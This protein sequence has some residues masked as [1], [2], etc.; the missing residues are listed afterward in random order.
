MKSLIHLRP[1]RLPQIQC[2]LWERQRQHLRQPPRRQSVQRL[3]PR[4]LRERMRSI[5]PKQGGVAAGWSWGY[6]SAVTRSGW[7]WIVDAHREFLMRKQLHDARNRPT[8]ATVHIGSWVVASYG[9]YDNRS[10]APNQL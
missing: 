10:T 2:R 5:L 8:D 6:C 3:R 1:R 9:T 4:L 7:R